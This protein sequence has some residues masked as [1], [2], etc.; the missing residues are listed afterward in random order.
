MPLNAVRPSRTLLPIAAVVFALQGA[1]A[2]GQQLEIQKVDATVQA[3][4]NV[5]LYL[6]ITR[7]DGQPVTL[8]PGDFKVF[9]DGKQIPAKKVKRALLPVKYAVDRYVMV[10]VDLSGPLVDSEY[11]ST[12]QDAVA[13]L[14][15]RV[16]KDARMGLSAFD[17]DGLVPFIG[18]DGGDHRAGLAA[19]RK[20]R[21]RSR[22]IDLWGRSS[23][24]WT[25]WT[26]RRTSR[27]CRTR[28]R[29]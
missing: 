4:A 26:G 29:P 20:F 27:R 15:E 11:L 7:K 6:K 2:T 13:T 17:G 3:P 25:S 5:A 12:L 8:L 22:N 14:A 10:V 18:L 16:G 19:M 21:P 24:R 23:R 9:E 1:C 28:R